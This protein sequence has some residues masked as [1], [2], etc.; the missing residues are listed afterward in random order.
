MARRGRGCSS[1]THEREGEISIAQGYRALH[2]G[3]FVVDDARNRTARARVLDVA[4]CRR[5]I[6]CTILTHPLVQHRLRFL[7][8]EHTANPEFLRLAG[9]LS[10]FVAYEAF[11]R[12]PARPTPWSTRPS[13]AA[14]RRR[15]S[16]T[17][18]SSCRSCVPGSGMVPA[19]QEVVPAQPGLPRRAAPQRDD[20]L[21]R[22]VPRRPARADRRRPRRRLRP[23]ARDGRLPDPGRRHARGARAPATSPPCA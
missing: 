13:R 18:T 23:D 8:D 11:R 4:Q 12:R 5:A 22:G 14:C 17:S 6:A 19:V 3:H 9:E 16:R 2:R 1:G 20:A 7:R 15:W 21:A 10:R